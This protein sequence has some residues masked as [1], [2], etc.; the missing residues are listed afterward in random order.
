M[1]KF[2]VEKSK[3]SDT[4]ALITGQDAN[5]IARVLRMEKG[6]S[7]VICDGEGFDYDGEISEI[8]NG[9]VSLLIKEKRLCPG[10]SDISVT[11]FQ[12]LPKGAKMELIIEKCT[13]L[14][15]SKVVPVASKYCVVK[16]ED[17]KK[18]AKKTE[19]WQK[20]ADEAAKQCLRG[21]IPKVENVLSLK[22][23]IK[24]LSDFDLSIVCYEHEDKTTLKDVLKVNKDAKKIA[25]FIGPEGGFSEEEIALLKDNGAFSITLGKRILRTETAGLCVI[26]AI[27]YEMGGF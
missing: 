11:L 17:A 21:V 2:F 8:S 23:A 27:M 15:V 24:L 9:E 25:I 16:L 19:K 1:P 22:D 4:R 14:G 3:I 18:E 5:H 10:E 26:S 13:E 12:C 7:L 20:T 6:D